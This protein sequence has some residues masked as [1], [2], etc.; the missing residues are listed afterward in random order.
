MSNQNKHLN[1]EEIF[2]KLPTYIVPN[3]LNQIPLVNNEISGFFYVGNNS[4]ICPNCD[5]TVGKNYWN[6]HQKSGACD[7]QIKRDQFKKEN[8]FGAPI[9]RNSYLPVLPTKS[10]DSFQSKNSDSPSPF[11]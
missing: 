1:L 2:N 9:I 6:Q 7:R 10:I 8:P 5:K 11:S 4:I 3:S